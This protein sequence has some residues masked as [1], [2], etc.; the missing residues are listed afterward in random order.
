VLC[1][2]A[3][4]R[5]PVDTCTPIAAGELVVTEVR[6][7]TDQANG[8]WIELFNASGGTLDLTGMQIRFRT[9]NDDKNIPILVR[10]EL[11]VAAGDYLVLGR[12]FDGAAPAHVD[13][14]FLDDFDDEDW[15]GAGAI[16]IGACAERVEVA[17]YSALPDTGT[18][19]LG[20]A[21]DADLN[22][23]PA[24]WCFDVTPEGT[25]GAANTPCPP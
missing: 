20:I 4:G 19:S 3:C 22:D 21:P 18:F 17:Q 13:Y 14:G 9:L 12:Y 1:L 5:D 23:D 2:A 11:T 8:S 10:R 16:D 15:L 25:P 6:G 24:S 7:D